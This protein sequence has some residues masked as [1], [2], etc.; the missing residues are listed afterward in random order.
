[1]WEDLVKESS[2][3]AIKNANIEVKDIYSCY[4]GNMNLSRFEGQDH[5]VARIN[6]ILGIEK[7]IRTEAACAS[8]S[9]ALKLAFNELELASLKKEDKIILVIG[10]EKMTDRITQKVT[11]ILAGASHFDTEVI[12]GTTFPGLYAII[13]SRYLYETN[14]K[15]YDLHAIAIKN[16]KN[17]M[18]NEKAMFRK[19]IDLEDFKVDVASPLKLLDCSPISDG[20]ASL[21]LTTEGLAKS[22]DIDYVKLESV[23]TA[24]STISLAKR[25]DLL[26]LDSAKKACEKAYK[27]TG[28]GAKDIDLIE[29]H[30]CFTIAE[31]LNLE[32]SGFAKRGEGYKLVRTLGKYEEINNKKAPLPYLVEGRKLYVNTSGG[33]KAKGHP[34]GATGAAQVVEVVNQLLGKCG[35]RNV[36]PKIGATL[37]IGG[38]GGSATFS[39]LRKP[40]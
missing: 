4:I 38:S 17:A 9:I 20:S 39:I 13:A 6:E 14:A 11:E 31:I 24:M 7:I 37:N 34:V 3:E 10:F 12:N 15:E 40:W 27:K 21:V 33:L 22:L 18:L 36:N 25:R 8:S 1:N 35:E 28:L 32:A 23:E 2:F 26:V 30:D 16:H 19:E 29:V 5:I